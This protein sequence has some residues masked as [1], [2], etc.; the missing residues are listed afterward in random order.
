MRLHIEGR[1]PVRGT[2]HVSGNSNA[3]L[4]LIAASMLADSS[5]T[6]TN[7]PDTIAVTRMLE[8]GT[9]LGM[10]VQRD[11]DRLVLDSGPVDGRGLER[12]YSDTIS[13]TLLF[14][15]P[16]LARRGYARLTIEYAVNRL[17]T[18][19][20]ALRDLGIQVTI[21]NGMVGVIDLAAT[22][23]DEREVILTQ[24]SVTA[25]TLV[26]MLA[27][28][29]GKRTTIINAA[30][31]PH[32]VDVLNLLA[33]MGAQIDGIG[34]N[35]LIVQGSA[36]LHGA[37]YAVS[38]DHVEA[39]SVAALAALSGGRLTIEGT[40]RRDMRLIAKAYERLGLQISL[41]MDAIIV[42]VH[43]RFEPSSREEDSDMP[44]DSAPWPGFPSDLIPMATVVATQSRG[45][46]LIHEKLFNNRMLFTDR[47][48]GMGAQIVLCDPH[49][50]IVVGATP[51]QGEY[52]D[53]PDV[54]TGLAMLGAA[55]CASGTTVIDNAEVFDRNFDHIIARLIPLGA[56]IERENG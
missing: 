10:T 42:P 55:L 16:I 14:V 2:Y 27:A 48:N 39:A 37:Q 54:R 5:V 21:S 46:F 52:V 43:E 41:D 7:V 35:V 19:L 47:L 40:R 50:A 53:N 28:L 17:N 15:A 6:L 18:H 34:S 8:V 49:R 33:A 51:L 29:L 26:A 56:K 13:G 11:G 22:P 31:E 45:T 24:T 44:I 20:T 9:A 1:Q 25:T 12:E 3:A 32:V 4:A 36:T 38:P 23:W 30:S